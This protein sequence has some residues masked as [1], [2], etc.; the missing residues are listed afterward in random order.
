MYNF[1]A[2]MRTM[3]KLWATKIKHRLFIFLKLYL[4]LSK[5]S[6]LS[7]VPCPKWKRTKSIEPLHSLVSSM[8]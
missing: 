7:P 8:P 6:Y 3:A 2:R 5:I 4:I 1:S